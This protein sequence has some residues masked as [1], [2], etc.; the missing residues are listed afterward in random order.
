MRIFKDSSRGY[1]PFGYGLLG[2]HIVLSYNFTTY[3]TKHPLF[4]R[5]E[6]YSGW[7]SYS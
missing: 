2:E 3:Y 7:Q 4:A 6:R 5:L 1:L